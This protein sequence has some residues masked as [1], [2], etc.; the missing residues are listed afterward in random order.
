MS[1]HLLFNP[2]ESTGGEN[3]LGRQ[4]NGCW[5]VVK[6][7]QSTAGRPEMITRRWLLSTS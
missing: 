3:I 4:G 2:E 7:A 5:G 1:L 6:G